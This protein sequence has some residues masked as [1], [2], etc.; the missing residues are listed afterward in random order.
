[1]TKLETLKTIGFGERVAEEETEILSTYFVETDYWDK[2]F[3]GEKDIIY[4]PK[5][6]GKSALYTLLQAKSGEL[7]DNGILIVSAENPRGATAFRDLS[8]DPPASEQEFISLWKLYI[9]VLLHDTLAEYSIKSPSMRKL[10]AILTNEGLIKGKLTLAGLLKKVT[11]YVRNTISA[12]ES[13]EGEIG[14]DSISGTP[15]AKGKIVFREPSAGEEKAGITS[16]ATILSFADSNS[17]C[18]FS[19]CSRGE[20]R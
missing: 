4:G 17:K 14:I 13:V 10:E 7:F 5:G 9:A 11:D 6:A 20:L 16:I 18:N 15:T 3:K 19:R 1:M 2:L 12:P 8:A